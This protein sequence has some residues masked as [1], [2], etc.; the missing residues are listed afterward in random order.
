MHARKQGHRVDVLMLDSERR[1]VVE[2]VGHFVR[3]DG[4][5]SN[6]R[7]VVVRKR[8]P[9]RTISQVDRYGRMK[10]PTSASTRVC[11]TTSMMSST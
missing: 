8:Y 5:R 7:C 9:T 10:V 6:R 11:V 4:R 1:E 3:V 2:E